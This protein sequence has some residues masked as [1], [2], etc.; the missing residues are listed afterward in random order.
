VSFVGQ[1]ACEKGTFVDA[2]ECALG[3]ALYSCHVAQKKKILRRRLCFSIETFGSPMSSE[4][5]NSST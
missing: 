2:R 4:T 5:S 3:N 1:F